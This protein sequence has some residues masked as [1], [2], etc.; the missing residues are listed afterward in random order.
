MRTLAL[1]ALIAVTA[2]ASFGAQSN[3]QEIVL[4]NAVIVDSKFITLGDLF[5]NA[6]DRAMKNIAYSPAPGKRAMFDAKWLYRVARVHGLKWRPLSL[7]TRAVVERASQEVRHEEIVDALTS[8]L[9]DQGL[10]GDFEVDFGGRPQRLFVAAD[11]PSTVGIETLRHDIRTGRFVAT[12]V[13][14]ANDPEAQ[15]IRLTGR[16]NQLVSVPVLSKRMLRGSVIHKQNLDWI[17]VR[18]SS[19]SA[20]TVMDA[21]QLIGMAAKRLMT[22]DLPIR[23]SQIRKP[24]LV[25]RGGLVNIRFQVPFMS[26]SAQ[27]QAL[28]EGSM[29]EVVR[30]VNSRSKKTIEARVTGSTTVK[31]GGLNSMALN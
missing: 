2:L 31:V 8:E 7:R 17:K 26:L 10:K 20:Q 25:T 4:K 16:I 21:D 23:F 28:D 1:A 12:L 6:G 30:V 13:V 9:R 27:G 24:L 22:A 3:A 11:R 14:P 5:E 15:R 29:G 19:T 18:R